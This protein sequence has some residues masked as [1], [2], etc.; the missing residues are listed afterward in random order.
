MEILVHTLAM[1]G[2]EMETQWWRAACEAREKMCVDSL[3]GLANRRRFDDHFREQWGLHQRLGQPMALVMCDVDHFKAYN[4]AFG[5]PAGDRCL[6]RVAA[7][8]RE[9]LHRPADLAARYGGEEF[10]LILPATDLEGA[11]AI[12]ES[13]RAALA[14]QAIAHCHPGPESRVTLSIGVAT[15]VPG[16]GEECR[17]LL[18]AADA[19]LYVAKAQGRDRIAYREPSEETP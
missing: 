18:D 2:D 5:H 4:D 11:L 1:H 16:P 14:A 10:A 12:A 19:L 3:T 9:A 13:A 6:E 7:A 17:R 15:R 8:L